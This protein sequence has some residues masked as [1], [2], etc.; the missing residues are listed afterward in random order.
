MNEK[1]GMAR[2][3]FCKTRPNLTARRSSRGPHINLA[4]NRAEARSIT[5]AERTLGSGLSAVFFLRSK[6]ILG[7]S[8]L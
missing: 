5:G 2:S 8:I 4:Y 1:N 6:S 7:M 3:T